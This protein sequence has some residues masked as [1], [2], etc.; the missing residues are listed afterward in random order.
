VLYRFGANL[1]H[2]HVKDRLILKDAELEPPPGLGELAWGRMFA[3]LHQ[4]AYDSY[5]S[6]EPHGACWT[7]NDGQLKRY[8]RLTLAHLKPFF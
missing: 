8:I 2:F 6:V 1:T 5:V 7:A 4:H 3:I